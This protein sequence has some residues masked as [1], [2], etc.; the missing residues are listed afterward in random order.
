MS[1]QIATSRW[2]VDLAGKDQEQ[3]E[4]TWNIITATDKFAKRQ[5][6]EHLKVAIVTYGA[7]NVP[8][9]IANA[10]YRG[11]GLGPI[12]I[13]TNDLSIPSILP[14][15]GFPTPGLPPPFK[16][17]TFPLP[18]LPKATPSV[19]VMSVP[20]TFDFDP[21]DLVD[22][23]GPV[24]DW[25][26]AV[27]KLGQ[28]ITRFSGKGVRVGIADSGADNDH[29]G[30]H[31]R[32]GAFRIVE[33][34]AHLGLL[35]DLTTPK[36]RNGHGTAV[37][38]I[39][40]GQGALATT[41]GI[42]PTSSLYAAV[43]TLEDTNA[44][45]DAQLVAALDWFASEKI[46]IA[47]IA[48]GRNGVVATG[49]DTILAAARRCGILP[50]VA[51]G[52]NGCGAAATPATSRYALSVGALAAPSEVASNSSCGKADGVVTLNVPKLLAPG[53]LIVAKRGTP[54][55][56]ILE[57]PYTSYAAPFVAGVAALLLEVCPSA[58]CD[59]LEAALLTT[60]TRIKNSK[61][62]CPEVGV[63]NFE[64]ALARLESLGLKCNSW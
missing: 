26:I 36:D 19:H 30:I 27:C 12:Y 50:I 4:K 1:P 55:L 21:A 2:I 53:T 14:P 64:A 58:S 56:T 63:L 38:S 54:P 51:V 61:C 16:G 41:W 24:L 8:T 18:G 59:Q 13:P 10:G 52:N 48:M 22:P 40:A 32:L 44:W 37:A 9:V 11:G 34:N 39:I 5:D 28:A 45:D 42:A 31:N 35:K 29:P 6:F 3:F 33:K 20:S 60:T 47:C 7:A 15:V 57:G 62:D 23:I 43:I 25:Q 17:P 49:H 46:P